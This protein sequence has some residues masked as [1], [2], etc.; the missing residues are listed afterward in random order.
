M[1]RLAMFALATWALLAGGCATAQSRKAARDAKAAE[2]Q[3][4]LEAF[5]ITLKAAFEAGRVKGPIDAGVSSRL[6]EW[7]LADVLR[8]FYNP[9]AGARRLA[10]ARAVAPD[11]SVLAVFGS[12]EDWETSFGYRDDEHFRSGE[13]FNA[14]ETALYE[15]FFRHALL[16]YLK[17][18]SAKQG[19]A[20][21]AA[22]VLKH[23][24][25][26]TPRYASIYPNLIDLETRQALEAWVKEE[27]ASVYAQR[28]EFLEL[29][30]DRN[31]AWAKRRAAIDA[32]MRELAEQTQDEWLKL[33]IIDALAARGPLPEDAFLMSLALPGLGQAA[34]GDLQGGLLLGALSVAAWWWAGGKLAVAQNDPDPATRAGAERDAWLGGGLGVLAHFFAAVNAA[35]WARMIN[36]VAEWDLL[37]HSR[38]K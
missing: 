26:L 36:V 23:A 28:V 29:W 15:P 21:A 32:R 10:S 13:I 12:P 30:D 14:Y 38:V 25:L 2:S 19:D 4:K 31:G 35:E 33:E 22:K 8:R 9:L 34:N 3:L 1:R 27:P 5:S 18:E 6:M 7:T 24:A 16:A 37:N 20:L 11:D 17:P